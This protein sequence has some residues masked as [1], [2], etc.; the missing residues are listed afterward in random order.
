MHDRRSK[1]PALTQLID[2]RMQRLFTLARGQLASN[3]A[4]AR[5]YVKLAR[6]L[7]TR[8]L[9]RMS[10]QQKRGFCKQCS[11]PWVSGETLRIRLN[12]K[13]KTIEYACLACGFVKRIP[14]HQKKKQK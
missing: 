12:T 7:G 1:A 4:R 13:Q 11:V 5:R 14:Y 2:E 3:P 6:K 9:V 10:P 8:Y